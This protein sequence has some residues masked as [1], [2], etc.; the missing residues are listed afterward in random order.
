M[1]NPSASD[2]QATK[3]TTYDS[4]KPSAGHAAT[5]LS[6]CHRTPCSRV[7]NIRCSRSENKQ[8]SILQ[9]TDTAAQTPCNCHQPA[10][11][12]TSVLQTLKPSRRTSYG[13]VGNYSS[14]GFNPT[15]LGMDADVATTA[16][17]ILWRIWMSLDLCNALAKTVR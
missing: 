6:F 10:L 1:R 7:G 5:H 9:G 11:R 12:S 2:P 3:Q 13:T 8:L 4:R 15:S 14:H 16:K 17:S